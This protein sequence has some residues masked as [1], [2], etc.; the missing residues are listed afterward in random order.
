MMVTE[1]FKI[2]LVIL[3]NAI[4]VIDNKVTI[5]INKSPLNYDD[6]IQYVSYKLY[7]DN[8]L[9]DNIANYL[10]FQDNEPSSYFKER[11]GLCKDN[12][13]HKNRDCLS[14]ERRIEIFETLLEKQYSYFLTNKDNEE[15]EVV[16][17]AEILEYDDNFS[18]YVKNMSS[19]YINKKLGIQTTP[20]KS[21]KKFM[22]IRHN[23]E[24][25]TL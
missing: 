21:P 7:N 4:Y 11:S 18:N 12:D 23:E 14:N 2:V 1:I 13:K 19:E 3:N 17:I 22:V 20:S 24:Y 16:K 8:N 6:F 25:K 10:I 9:V 5:D 15:S